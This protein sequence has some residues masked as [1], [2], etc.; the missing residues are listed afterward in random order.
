MNMRNL[1]NLVE[2]QLFEYEDTIDALKKYAHDPEVFVH[3]SNIPKFGFY[4]RQQFAQ[5]PYGYYGFPLDVYW[6]DIQK[7]GFESGGM[8]FGSRNYAIVFRCVSDKVI[9]MT[10]Y[11]DD[12]LKQDYEKLRTIFAEM[13]GLDRAK[14]YGFRDPERDRKISDNLFRKTFSDGLRHA[15]ALGRNDPI[16]K[17]WYGTQMI[18]SDFAPIPTEKHIFWMKLLKRCGY[19]GF[20]DRRNDHPIIH[21]SENHQAVFFTPKAIKLIEILPNVCKRTR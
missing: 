5:T 3:F 7:Y 4:P 19:D 8:I 15:K 14:A 9:E 20:I 12:D 2:Q 10:N 1:I 11:T 13:I 17:L 21:R 18:T 6:D 16:H